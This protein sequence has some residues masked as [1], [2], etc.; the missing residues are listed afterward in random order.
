MKNKL[1]TYDEVFFEFLEMTIIFNQI[2]A[3]KIIMQYCKIL[4]N[5]TIKICSA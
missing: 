4:K 2:R 1:L 5:N 3:I